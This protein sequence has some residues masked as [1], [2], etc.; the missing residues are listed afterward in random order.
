MTGSSDNHH[1]R[2]YSV[3]TLRDLME[4]KMGL[5]SDEKLLY[6]GLWLLDGTLCHVWNDGTKMPALFG[7]DAD[8][9]GDGD[10]DDGDADEDGDDGD[11]DDDDDD[12]DL[13]KIKDPKRRRAARQAAQ[14]RTQRNAARTERDT[15][16]AKVTDLETKLRDAEAK[17]SGD[18]ALKARITTL[19][20][21]LSDAVKRA[22]KAEGAQRQT[23]I[24][25]QVTTAIR[26]G[27]ER[28]QEDDEVIMILLE[29]NGM[30]EADEDGVVDDLDKSLRRL[31]RLGKIHVVSDDE[32]DEDD[33]EDDKRA[34]GSKK[35]SGRTF[36]GKKKASDT[37]DRKALEEKFPALKR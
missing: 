27:K 18:E 23:S 33:D 17:G 35:S 26:E 36:N 34:S 7:F 37:Y 2:T 16:K 8:E 10:G 3:G 20:S 21:E 11:D 30:L 25:R 9:D 24:Q 1:E 13:D 14:Y 6:M 15:L 32:D 22:D 12:D 28:F 31:K 4:A 19:E 29:R 5:R